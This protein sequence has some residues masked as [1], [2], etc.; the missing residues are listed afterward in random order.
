MSTQTPSEPTP[1]LLAI[2]ARKGTV[3]H[4]QRTGA[5]ARCGLFAPE[6]TP[7]PLTDADEQYESAHRC[8]SPECF[9]GE[10]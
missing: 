5:L 6:A 1:H 9:G 2:E 10:R 8:Q 7:L 4:R 3:L